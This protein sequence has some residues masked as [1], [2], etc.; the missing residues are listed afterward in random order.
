MWIS[1]VVVFG[2]SL[3]L[4]TARNISAAK[5]PAT[6]DYLLMSIAAYDY[7]WNSTLMTALASKGYSIFMQV[8]EELRG[9]G[10]GGLALRHL[11]TGRIIISHTGTDTFL[12]WDILV[13]LQ[14]ILKQVPASLP[15]ALAFTERVRKKMREQ[16]ISDDD[17]IFTGHSLGAALSSLTAATTKRK[18]IVFECPGTWDVL[19]DLGY[20]N[21]VDVVCYNSPPNCVN[22]LN[23]HEGV[24]YKLVDTN[25]QR[26]KGLR[27]VFTRIWQDLISCFDMHAADY[28]ESLFDAKTGEPY[29]LVL[30]GVGNPT[31]GEEEFDHYFHSP[32]RHRIVFEI[33]I[34]LSMLVIG[35]VFITFCSP[36]I[37]KK[38]RTRVK[39]IRQTSGGLC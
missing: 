10:Y 20:N 32:E 22:T 28:L 11:P 35:T 6:L 15:N 18:A 38:R 27:L 14:M 34:L 7:G 13:D 12:G 5:P 30:S 16:N 19:H 4:A 29:S 17:L 33:Y 37:L 36:A 25:G 24:V 26:P 8:P 2:Y 3:I 9:Y 21:T 39:F 31:Q 23:R 1:L